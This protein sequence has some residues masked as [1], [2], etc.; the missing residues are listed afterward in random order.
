MKLQSK[1]NSVIRY[2]AHI[3]Q[4]KAGVVFNLKVR[5]KKA[6]R[7]EERHY[8]IIKGSIHLRHSNPKCKQ[9]KQQSFKI[10]ETKTKL[11]R[12]IGK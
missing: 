12:E 11:R 1:K 6:I 4:K 3:N 8:I 7:D 9:T 10:Y 5:A 2:H